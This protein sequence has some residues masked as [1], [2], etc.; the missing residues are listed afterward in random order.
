MEK[1][2]VDSRDIC[3]FDIVE[4]TDGREATIVFV[5]KDPTTGFEADIGSGPED[6]DTISIKAS[7]IKRIVWHAG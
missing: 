3:E 6:W 1:A 2:S 5:P 7:Q 4:L